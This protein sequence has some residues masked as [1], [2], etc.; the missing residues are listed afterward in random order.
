METRLGMEHPPIGT[1]KVVGKLMLMGILE[2]VTYS[3]RVL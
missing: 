2:T 1:V 3:L